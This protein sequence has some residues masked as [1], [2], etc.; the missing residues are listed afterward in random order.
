MNMQ[1]AVFL[2]ECAK[3]KEGKMQIKNKNIKPESDFSV[4]SLCLYLIV[5]KG[6]A[7]QAEELWVTVTPS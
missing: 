6:R 5:L 4:C 3:Y 2:P 1:H 7:P